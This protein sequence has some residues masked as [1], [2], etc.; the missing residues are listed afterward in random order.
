MSTPEVFPPE[1]PT[2]QAMLEHFVANFYE[3]FK[4]NAPDGFFT[5]IRNNAVDGSYWRGFAQGKEKGYREGYSAA[6][7]EIQTA[8]EVAHQV[9]DGIR[10][11]DW[12]KV[13]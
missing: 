2:P 4:G 1:E 11:I 12:R 3:A 9:I 6:K 7:A 8:E 5:R 13:D 10:K